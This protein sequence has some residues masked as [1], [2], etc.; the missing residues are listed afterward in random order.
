MR[1][2]LKCVSTS[3]RRQLIALTPGEPAGIGPDLAAVIASEPAHDEIVLVADRDL[4]AARARQ[5]GLALSLR[6]YRAQESELGQGGYRILHVPLSRP[7]I[8]GCLDPANATYVLATLERAL[9]GCLRGEF[10][11]LVTG[12][13]QKSVIN[14]AGYPFTGHTEFLAARAG[15]AAPVMMLEADDLRVA[16][17]TTHLPLRRVYEQITRQR[18]EHVVMTVARHLESRLNLECPRIAV[19]GLNPHAGEGGHLGTEDAEAIAPAVAACR[20]TGL[21]VDGPLPADTAFTPG[22]RARFD[23]YVSMFHDQGLPV[24]KALGFGHAVNVTLGLPLVRTSVDHGT[25]L[26]LAGTGRADAGSLRA[27]L[28]LAQRLG[29]RGCET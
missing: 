4:I 8:P 17:V 28:A 5:L 16:L 27:A 1:L 29:A 22:M 13:V 12:P 7:A 2:T 23:C 11:A 9:A 6:E 10:A 26:E 21:E 3:E 15:G 25:A 20:A 19:C 14:D 18:V 24:L